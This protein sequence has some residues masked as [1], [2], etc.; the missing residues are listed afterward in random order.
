MLSSEVIN[1]KLSALM[2]KL[3]LTLI[4]IMRKQNII[5]FIVI[6][7]M[8]KAKIHNIIQK[9]IASLEIVLLLGLGIFKPMWGK[10]FTYYK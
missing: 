5:Y 8:Y 10:S 2:H 3:Y 7:Y 9:N 6:L 1:K 4:F